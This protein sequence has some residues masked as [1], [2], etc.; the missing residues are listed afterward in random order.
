MSALLDWDDPHAARARPAV[1]AIAPKSITFD[2]FMIILHF[3]QYVKYYTPF[4]QKYKAFLNFF[5]K[6]KISRL[7]FL[8]IFVMVRLDYAAKT[9]RPLRRR[10]ANTRRPFL[11]DIRLRNPCLRARRSLLG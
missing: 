11:V 8:L 1:K 7:E 10:A 3:L 4:E 6:I 5:T 9:L 2:F